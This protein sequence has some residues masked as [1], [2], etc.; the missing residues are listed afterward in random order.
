MRAQSRI[1][2]RVATAIAAVALTLTTGAAV[3]APTAPMA[4]THAFVQTH[5]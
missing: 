1:P 2:A 4:Q 3:V 5:A